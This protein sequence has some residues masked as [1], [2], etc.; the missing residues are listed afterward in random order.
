MLLPSSNVP[1]TARITRITHTPLAEG[2]PPRLIYT[3]ATGES[4]EILGEYAI[5]APLPGGRGRSV[6]AAGTMVDLKHQTHASMLP[7]STGQAGVAARRASSEIL[8]ARRSMLQPTV[9]AC[10]LSFPSPGQAG[11]LSIPST[12]GRLRL[13]VP[14]P[15]PDHARRG[16]RRAPALPQP[17]G[18]RAVG[19][20][21]GRGV[22]GRA[23]AAGRAGG[24][25][26]GRGRRGAR[27]RGARARG[28]AALPP[29]HAGAQRGRRGRAA[30]PGA[31]PARLPA[32]DVTCLQGSASLTCVR[33]TTVP[34]AHAAPAAHARR[35]QARTVER[36]PHCASRAPA[37]H[38]SASPSC[39]PAAGRGG[40]S[41]TL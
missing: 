4:R 41:Q 17:R 33:G 28:A 9:P 39:A 6:H 26:G 31:P 37:R 40:V 19:A 36:A 2:Q 8:S 1:E 11:C 22:P 35:A 34:R 13:P 24:G 32:G 29:G 12:A 15:P 23:G 20:A 30:L 3:T 10:H 14:A 21:V 5:R 16:R 27:R 25:A 7:P 38:L 18:A